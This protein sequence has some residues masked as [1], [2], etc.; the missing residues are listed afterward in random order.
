MKYRQFGRTDD[1]VS[2]IILGTW[3]FGGRNFGPEAVDDTESIATI[4]AA[5]DAGITMIDTAEIYGSGR[6]EEVVGKAL[7]GRRDKVKIA[8]KAWKNHLTSEGIEEGL[9]GSLKRLGTDYVDLYIVHW[10]VDDVP[11]EETMTKLAECKEDG[12]IRHIGV[13]NFPADLMDEA[14]KITRFESLQPPY[15]LYW[16]YVEKNDTP[17]CVRNGISVTP[18][19]P[20]AQG[21]LTGKFKRDHQFGEGDIRSNSYLFKGETYQIACDGVEKL[22]AMAGDMGCPVMHLALAWLLAQPGVTAPIVGARRPSQLEGV[23]GAVD[24]SLSAEQLAEITAA[25]DAVMKSLG[26]KPNNMWAG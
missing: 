9:T 26:D 1:T 25:G 22:E 17:F 16:R 3:V 20:M 21:L 13:S 2:E 18:Y 10:P 23:L 5:L 6:S 19:S 7:K 24:V 14:L 4:H 12:R 15:S 11:V 8:T